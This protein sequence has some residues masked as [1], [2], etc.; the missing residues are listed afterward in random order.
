MRH[1]LI[2]LLLL[3]GCGARHSDGISDRDGAAMSEAMKQILNKP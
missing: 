1:L 3:A 2:L